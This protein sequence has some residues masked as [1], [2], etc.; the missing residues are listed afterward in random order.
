MKGLYKIADLVVLI[1]YKYNYTKIFLQEYECKDNLIV[2]FSISITDEELNKELE[3]SEVKILDVVESTCI[4]RKFAFML[5]TK[6]NGVLFHG[7]SVLYNNK[8][9][10]FTA[11]SG[12]GKST[13]TK[14]LKDL[15]GDK[16]TYIND[17]KPIIRYFDN[18]N[19]FY[20]YG[21]PWNGKHFL[22]NNIKAPLK[23]VVK[24]E[25]G[26]KNV[27]TKVSSVS[28]LSFLIEQS[29]SSS[30]EE[31][32]IKRF[33][34]VSKMLEKVKFYKLLCTKDISSASETYLK[35]LN[36]EKLWR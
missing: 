1:E 17:D 10:A 18:E 34:I 16:I 13:H 5:T 19:C 24:I 6:Y 7:S 35:I 22:S 4:L 9:Y 15:L 8:A 3:F 2:D 33:E 21:S 32:Q 30:D 31:M 12:V 11:K 27:A 28:A 29:Y 14:N 25:R 26:D 36:E 23:A 20:V